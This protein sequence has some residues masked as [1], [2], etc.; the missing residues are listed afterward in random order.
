MRRGERVQCF[1]CGWIRYLDQPEPANPN[2]WDHDK[3]FF[4]S[5]SRHNEIR[6]DMFSVYCKRHCN[7]F[8]D[9]KSEIP[10]QAPSE[11]YPK[12]TI[13]EMTDTM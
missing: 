4:C 11:R 12:G 3:Y 10:V 1:H 7:D 9:R 8:R 6:R 13:M 2:T 5:N